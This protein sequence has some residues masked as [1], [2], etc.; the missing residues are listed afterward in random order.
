M[1]SAVVISTSSDSSISKKV[2]TSLANLDI[3][4]SILK[5]DSSVPDA[6]IFTPDLKENYFVEND[7]CLVN[8]GI[9]K[10]FFRKKLS[11]YSFGYLDD[12][13]NLVCSEGSLDLGSGTDQLK[14]ACFSGTLNEKYCTKGFNGLLAVDSPPD[15][16][17]V[18]YLFHFKYPLNI[19]KAYISIM[20]KVDR[21]KKHPPVKILSTP[22]TIKVHEFFKKRAAIC[23]D[24]S[25][26]ELGTTVITWSTRRFFTLL[27]QGFRPVPAT[28][29][30]A[31]WAYENKKRTIPCM[32]LENPVNERLC[33]IKD[34]IKSHSIDNRTFKSS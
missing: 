17:P 32:I 6:E 23:E 18:K 22:G 9:R 13:E 2:I 5:I 29:C 8:Y 25:E 7:H 16:I 4:T 31:L 26:L 21:S 20:D 3:K 10:L 11:F 24:I 12:S 14:K 19:M 30:L 1:K 28:R 15:T 33:I 27:K 34:H